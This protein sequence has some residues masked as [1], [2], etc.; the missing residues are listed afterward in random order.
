MAVREEQR[1]VKHLM[2]TM[3]AS[4]PTDIP[5]LIT[6]YTALTHVCYLFSIPAEDPFTNDRRGMNQEVSKFYAGQ[7][8][9][10]LPVLARIVNCYHSWLYDQHGI[11]VLPTPT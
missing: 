3:D 7:V 10:H 8:R 1:R 4:S 6:F 9:E 5:D 2:K 11:H